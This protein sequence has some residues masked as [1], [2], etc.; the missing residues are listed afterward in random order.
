MKLFRKTEIQALEQAGEREGVS[1]SEMMDRAGA[2]LAR[3]AVGS[4]GLPNRAALLCGRGNNGGDGFVCAG[5]LAGMGVSCTVILLHGEPGTELSMAAFNR[6]PESVRVLGLGAEAEAAVKTQNQ[7]N[8]DVV[9]LA[10]TA[11]LNNKLQTYRPYRRT[12]DT[13]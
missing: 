11:P 4:W 6:L 10:A 1:L 13:K 7:R 9:S 5:E 2:S 3:L 12:P 8:S